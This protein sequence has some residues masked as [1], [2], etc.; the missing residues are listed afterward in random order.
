MRSFGVSFV[1]GFGSLIVYRMG[2]IP[3][4]RDLIHVLVFAFHLGDTCNTRVRVLGGD[5]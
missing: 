3:V 4:V 1:H 2:E 5:F